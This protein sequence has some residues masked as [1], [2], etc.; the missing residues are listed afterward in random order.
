MR[1]DADSIAGT[2]SQCLPCHHSDEQRQRRHREIAELVHKLALLNPAAS[3]ILT[4]QTTIQ[5]PTSSDA[6]GIAQ[7]LPSDCTPKTKK[8]RKAAKKAKKIADLP[9][10]LTAATVE[11]VGKVLRP[12]DYGAED[13]EIELQLLNDP[14]INENRFFHKGT[15]NQRE[16]RNI[17]VKKDRKD[18]KVSVRIDPE[19]MDGLLQLLNVSPITAGS[20]SEEKRIVEMLKHKIEKDLIQAQEE[21]E[22]LM[23]RKAGFWRW[24]SK[25][26]YNRLVANGCIWE[27]KSDGN[28]N[29]KGDESVGSSEGDVVFS[30]SSGDAS[31]DTNITE[32]D[33]D[34][35]AVV[36][37]AVATLA[38]STPKTPK[39][40]KTV[41][42]DDGWTSVSG[43]KGK[44]SG[45]TKKATPNV[46]IKL[47]ANKGLSKLVQSSTPPTTGFLRYHEE[48]D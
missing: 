21:N 33:T 28:H 6:D 8:E 17:F 48:D 29:A 44:G 24:A 4:A 45:K 34:G 7:G 22:G 3:A 10:A 40:A 20:S 39:M 25:K 23:M 38:M 36:A 27:D 43:A 9:K 2:S 1:M 31:D 42:M 19:E 18:D 47:S 13:A 26:A 12:N 16:V 32:P 5:T 41:G 30:T 15:S 14:E 11:H 46:T 37:E 35:V